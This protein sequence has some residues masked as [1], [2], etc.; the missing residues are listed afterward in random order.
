M[1]SIEYDALDRPVRQL[2]PRKSGEDRR[3]LH[4]RYDAN[5][6]L[7][8]TTLPVTTASLDTLL[9]N[10]ESA[11][12]NRKKSVTVLDHFDPGWVRTSE[13]QSPLIR[14]D[15]SAEGWQTER[16]PL[17]SGST[18]RRTTT[19]YY[20]DGLLKTHTNHRGDRTHR[21]Y[22]RNGNLTFVEDA[23]VSSVRKPITLDIDHSGFDQVGST[24][25]REENR[26][27]QVTEYTYLLDGLVK[28]RADDREETSGGTLVRAARRHEFTYDEDGN[29]LQQ[30]DLG[31][32][33]GRGDDK[34]I[35]FGYFPTD[36]ER[37]RVIERWTGSDAGGAFQTRQTT[38]R[39]YFANGLPSALRT[40]G[41]VVDAAKLRE[42]HALTY[43]DPAGVYSNGHRTRDTFFRT[44]PGATVPCQ[45][46]ANPCTQRWAYDG[47]DRLIEENDG[48][49]N[50]SG[51][52]LT[53]AGGVERKFNAETNATIATAEFDGSRMRTYTEGLTIRMHYDGEG[54]LDCVTDPDGTQADDCN[55]AQGEESPRLWQDYAYDYRNR[56]IGWRRPKEDK[57]ATFDHDALDRVIHE[58]SVD[59]SSTT[60]RDLSYIGASRDVAEERESGAR[61]RTRS[62]SYDAF[63][64]RIGLT[65][66][67]GSDAEQELTYGYDAHG[68]VTQLLDDAGQAKAS[69][70]Y[71]AYGEADGALTSERLPG[72]NEEPEDGETVNPFRYS[73]KRTDPDTGQVDMGVRQFGP[74]IGQFLQEDRFED[75]IGD[76]DLA[77]DPLTSNRYALAAG[78]PISFVEQDGHRPIFESAQEARDYSKRVVEAQTEE[79]ESSG[80]GGVNSSPGGDAAQGGGTAGG[81][82]ASSGGS[83][84]GSAP[85]PQP[86]RPDL[87]EALGWQG[88]DPLG[89]TS[90]PFRKP[91]PPCVT[92]VG[93]ALE[94]GFV[95]TAAGAAQYRK[96]KIAENAKLRRS[97][98]WWKR[99]SAHYGG[100]PPAA[101]TARSVTRIAGRAGG[102][103][104]VASG[105]IEGEGVGRIAVKG[106]ASGFGASVGAA[107]GTAC[108][109]G[110]PVCVAVGAAVGG[111]VGNMAGEA[112][113]DVLDPASEFLG[114]TVGFDP[115]GDL[116]ND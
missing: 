77:T 94:C 66:K 114:D 99:K 39:E 108:T 26:N 62:Y 88:G 3:Y 49:G 74:E 80:S 82:A 103:T 55:D 100:A 101:R 29:L 113:A 7:T 106:A 59:G 93:D 47:A 31:R 11:A 112:A 85:A 22:D 84:S 91:E 20:R 33:P 46:A 5:S 21:R 50:R 57:R 32:D 81:A 116:F 27:T 102:V 65:Y 24:T 70:G 34:R 23:G 51:F 35:S 111:A 98:T 38:R 10:A 63:G 97:G 44:S 8:H 83:G 92:K 67:R 115:V 53:A 15:Y 30:L 110:A 17:R 4:R 105:V 13:D 89:G 45:D 48:H 95:G 61:D 73:G 14:F 64:R 79:Q 69:Y 71:K 2:L 68:N 6:N 104:S 52:E 19:D 78:N 37:E 36:R 87:G 25:A 72:S 18:S 1:S 107:A 76:L 90:F 58:Q 43:R 16:D 109:V 86:R 60:D 56:Q 9:A 75:A 28:T 40:Y 54:N 96:Q 12:E 41:G 42:S